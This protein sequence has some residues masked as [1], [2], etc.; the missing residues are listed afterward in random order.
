MASI[1]DVAKVT[2]IHFD[3]NYRETLIAP[4][5]FVVYLAKVVRRGTRLR[6]MWL[7]NG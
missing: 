2:F 6:E 1:K 4:E 5:D 7:K 3:P